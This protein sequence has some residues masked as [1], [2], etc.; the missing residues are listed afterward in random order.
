MPD[1]KFGTDGWR[2][3]MGDTR[4]EAAL[5]TARVE[6]EARREATRTPAGRPA[7]GFGRS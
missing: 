2:A 7:A 1:I 4:E 3:I 6:E 5:T